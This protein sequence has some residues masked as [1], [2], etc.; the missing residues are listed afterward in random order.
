[1]T[2]LHTTNSASG[3][4]GAARV[5]IA[6]CIGAAIA[7]GVGVGAYAVWR[8]GRPRPANVSHDF[9][10]LRHTDTALIVGRQTGEFRPGFKHARCI[11]VAPG[12]DVY[13]SGDLA[14]RRFDANGTK[15]LEIAAAEGPG[16]ITV[17]AGG[18]IYATFGAKV[19]VYD[20]NGLRVAT[21]PVRKNAMFTSIA[22]TEAGVFV[23][24][25]GGRVVLRYDGEG[26]VQ[27]VIG[28]KDETRNAPGFIVPSPYFD[29]AM[30]P[31]GLLWVTNPGRHQV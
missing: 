2:Q 1:M 14:I 30:A 26:K 9:A 3:G 28:K 29:L 25:F 4:P 8:S 13:V 11:A 5:A 27:A 15:L 21:W 23:A 16:A 22:A 24:D 19:W 6:I 20:P 7:V 10:P 12:G 18:K 31:D 17:G